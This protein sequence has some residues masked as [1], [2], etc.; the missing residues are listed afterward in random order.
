MCIKEYNIL[1]TQSSITNDIYLKKQRETALLNCYLLSFKRLEL[2]CISYFIGKPAIELS[3]I[4]Y[5]FYHNQDMNGF[6]PLDFAKSFNQMS[7][8]IT[9][10]MASLSQ[11]QGIR[12]VEMIIG[13]VNYVLKT[14]TNVRSKFPGIVDQLREKR[15]YSPDEENQ[16]K[17]AI[18]NAIVIQDNLKYELQKIIDNQKNEKQNLI[19]SFFKGKNN[20]EDPIVNSFRSWEIVSQYIEGNHI[21]SCDINLKKEIQQ[22]FRDGLDRYSKDPNKVFF[23][24]NSDIFKK[25]SSGQEIIQKIMLNNS[26]EISLEKK[27]DLNSKKLKI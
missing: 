12:D 13:S 7:E 15:D 11:A 21:S 19:S 22:M 25:L 17:M 9:E 26:L 10:K 8:T 27:P 24:D 23:P 16:V 2:D 4:E 14:G 18:S 20:Q 5:L 6:Y 1:M 3:V